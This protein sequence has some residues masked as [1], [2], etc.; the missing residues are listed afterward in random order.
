MSSFHSA[1]FKYEMT[2]RRTDDGSGWRKFFGENPVGHFWG[3]PIVRITEGFTFKLG[4]YAHP[5]YEHTIPAGFECDLGTA[6]GPL[7]LIV[8]LLVKLGLIKEN[9]DMVATLHDDMWGKADK[10]TDP[11]DQ[12]IC[13][14]I[15]DLVFYQANLVRG[16][17]EWYAKTVYN[18]VR[19]V[20]R[21]KLFS[22]KLIKK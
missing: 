19:V 11:V 10:V 13:Y 3:R 22:R 9:L 8:A 20:G 6:P 16:Q 5:F 18:I 17:P 12:M 4:D 14:H 2:G 15:S 1:G 21:L 7:K